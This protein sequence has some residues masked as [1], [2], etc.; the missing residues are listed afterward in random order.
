MSVTQYIGSR[1]VPVFA[2]PIEW[3]SSNT[4]EPLTIVIHEGNSYTSKQA[5][6]KDID[7]SNEAFWA[8]TGNYNA[9][10]ELYRRETANA[11]TA[12]QNAQS[13][14]DT[15]LPKDQFSAAN[16]I[17]DAILESQNNI[18]NLP[19]MEIKS[20]AINGTSVLIK[21][22]NR[23]ILI[24]CGMAT[25]SVKFRAFL[26]AEVQ[27]P[28]D[29]LVLSHFHYDHVGNIAS[30]LQYCDNNTNI[31]IQMPVTRQ[32]VTQIETYRTGLQNLL[33]AITNA[34]LTIVPVVP[35]ENDTITF[36]TNNEV[37]PVEITF[38]NTNPA[39]EDD[40]IYKSDNAWDSTSISINNYSL[41]TTIAFAHNIYIN[42][43]DIESPA[44][45]NVLPYMKKAT[46]AMIPHHN[47]NVM[48]LADFFN[49]VDADAWHYTMPDNQPQESAY[50]YLDAINAYTYRYSRQIK[51]ISIWGNYQTA[52][53]CVLNNGEIIT[54]DGSVIDYAKNIL[55]TNNPITSVFPLADICTPNNPFSIRDYSIN[56]LISAANSLNYGVTVHLNGAMWNM[57]DSQMYSDIVAIFN[58]NA[59][60][61]MSGN[62][63]VFDIECGNAPLKIYNRLVQ[64]IRCVA[65]WPTF[66]MAA[67]P[68]TNWSIQYLPDVRVNS[69]AFDEWTIGN[70]LSGNVNF[71]RIS[72]N[73]EFAVTLQNSV[74]TRF[75]VNVKKISDTVFQGIGLVSN[76]IAVVAFTKPSATNY[77]FTLTQCYTYNLTA[78]PVS[79][80]DCSVVGAFNIASRG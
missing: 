78:N 30:A 62:S 16:T 34:G 1:Y 51:N 48:G 68:D 43:G 57:Y 76:G 64:P 77:N 9:Q 24:D 73:L 53:N 6:P 25:D 33:N 15:L 19:S 71:N 5:V 70:V 36:N 45:I 54:I 49:K 26:N 14:I 61:G 13:D 41:V 28:I 40:Y 60:E 18:A 11:L 47:H 10:V 4:Y 72:N 12:A 80:A 55:P 46:L 79:R 52:F 44:E 23:Q 32:E 74:G 35:T 39:F 2:D 59:R 37:Y 7:I 22:L 31:Y 65:L 20:P 3:S 66:N 29:V 58:N 63:L 56:D 17:Y 38:N 42:T 67:F 75:N 21:C 27:R 8:L 50:D 69:T